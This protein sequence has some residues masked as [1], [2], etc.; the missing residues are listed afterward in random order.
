[1]ILDR[2][3]NVTYVD[4]KQV[5]CERL[6][7]HGGTVHQGE[8]H[9]WPREPTILQNRVT[10]KKTYQWNGPPPPGWTPPKEAS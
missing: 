8:G 7:R 4:G 10:L 9:T 5:R 3:R 1:M 2:C 6:P